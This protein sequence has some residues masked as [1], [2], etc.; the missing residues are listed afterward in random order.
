MKQVYFV[1]TLFF[2]SLMILS[3]SLTPATA[4][5]KSNLEAQQNGYQLKESDVLFMYASA[6]SSNYGKYKADMVAWGTFGV[7]SRIPEIQRLGI[8]ATGTMW[9]LTA[10]AWVL[11]ENLS[12]REA[13]ARDILGVPIVVQ[14]LANDD[15]NGVKSY[16]GCVN[17]PVFSNYLQGLMRTECQYKPDGIHVD[18]PLGGS[19]ESTSFD[20]GCF[21]DYCMA[22]F[23]EWLR[24]NNRTNALAIAGVASFDAFNYKTLILSRVSDRQ[25][26]IQQKY[27]LPLFQEFL[28]YQMESALNNFISLQNTAFSLLGRNITYSANDYFSDYGREGIALTPYLTHFVQEVE[29]HAA[30]GTASLYNVIKACRQAE[31]LKRP[32]AATATGPDWAFIKINNATNLVKIWIGLSYAC[33]QRL[34]VPD[35]EH[36]WCLTA[37]GTEWYQAPIA[38]FSP[39]YLFVKNYPDLFDGYK[40]AGP[41]K[42]PDVSINNLSSQEGRDVFKTLLSAGNPQPLSSADGKIWIFPRLKDGKITIHLINTDYDGSQ[43]RVTIKSNVLLEIPSDLV[44]ASIV[45]GNVGTLYSYD[46]VPETVSITRGGNIAQILIPEIRIWSVINFK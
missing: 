32:L 25:Q 3:C 16:W 41:L 36:Q 5:N 2:Y 1:L 34:M 24:R 7:P 39:L 46:K 44:P 13:V 40:T 17:N 15:C 33:G 31:A 18:D 19:F 6:D 43:D 21:C 14:W 22:G 4:L 35:P 37:Q 45:S 38:A 27:S 20:G 23:R 12:L 26:Y 29:F 8:R 9:C 42:A 30:E 28:D 11:Y 10:T